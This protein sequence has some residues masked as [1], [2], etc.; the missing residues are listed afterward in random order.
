[1]RDLLAGCFYICNVFNMLQILPVLPVWF[2]RKAPRR[3]MVAA[4]HRIIQPGSLSGKRTAP[5]P[6]FPARQEAHSGKIF[7]PSS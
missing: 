5:S 4:C 1:M 7:I 3:P 6:S 2:A